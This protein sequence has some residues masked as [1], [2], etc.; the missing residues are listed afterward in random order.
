VDGARRRGPNE[1]ASPGS[2][3]R[4]TNARQATAPA[5]PSITGQAAAEERAQLLELLVESSDDAI[6]SKTIEGVITSWNA[7]A[8]RIYGYSEAEAIGKNVS[9]LA[10][11]DRA[12]EILGILATMVKGERVSH[13]T[14]ER[15]RKD[16][17]RIHVALSV[18]VLL[19]PDGVVVGA[20]TIARD[21]TESLM[22]ARK[23][24]ESE[25]K[26]RLLFE[27][28]RT[29]CVY[30]DAGGGIVD[31]NP[32]AERILGRSLADMQGRTSMDPAWRSIREDGTDFPGE[33][34]PLAIA[35]RT[36]RAVSGVVC[37]VPNAKQASYRWVVVGATP[38]RRPDESDPYLFCATFED[39]TELKSA[40]VALGGLVS[41]LAGK[42]EELDAANEE[43]HAANEELDAA[44]EE[45]HAA[46]ED[47]SAA[48]R[49]KSEFLASMSHELRTPLN[50][51]IGFSGVLAQGL[52][53]PLT[54]EQ[55]TQLAMISRAGE[56]LLTLI[57]EILDL[58]RIESGKIETRV[59]PIDV[60]RI[61]NEVVEMLRPL[62]AARGL[63]LVTTIDGRVAT[64]H[65]DADK[66]R[67]ILANVVGNAVKFTDQGEVRLVVRMNRS[68][69]VRFIVQDTG[70]GIAAGDMGRIFERFERA[71]NSESTKGG[72][73]LGLCIA[74]EYAEMLGGEL[75]ATSE[76][77]AGSAFTLTLPL[78]PPRR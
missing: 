63:N 7:G 31:V 51:V 78:R 42:N 77:G 41:E 57:N 66:V 6:L 37:G 70:P 14:T 5:V 8:Q 54:D 2:R 28:M 35:R 45:L 30:Q 74:R 10:P 32:E 61:S 16:G 40:Q 58:E 25:L 60:E 43:L 68:G 48:S 23:L 76:I 59:E 18:S 9:M 11:P 44:N 49:A 62:A 72:T 38:L 29:G 53:G 73:G 15:V 64:L 34:H 1:G 65:S 17:E 12:D 52:A 56:H 47:L 3:D 19:D 46:N 69:T 50:S 75:D 36:G 27:S 24:E 33:E 13:L 22:L 39:V 26:H 21:V 20:M 67:Q 55:R 71:E 4:E